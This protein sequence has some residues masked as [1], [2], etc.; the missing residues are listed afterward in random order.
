MPPAPAADR[1]NQPSEHRP[2][3]RPPAPEPV[4]PLRALLRSISSSKRDLLSLLP[5]EAYRVRI[6]PLGSS[7]RGI[8]LINEPAVIH[9]IMVAESGEFPKNDLFVGALAPLVGNGVFISHGQDWTRQRR[10]IEPGF[11]H[12]HLQRAYPAMLGAV[13]ACLGRLE[14]FVPRGD[15][16]S[17]NAAMTHVTADVMCRTIFSE[18]LNGGAAER[19]FAAFGRFQDS[20]A[21]VDVL[22]LLL[23]R[24][25]ARVAQPKAAVKAGSDI[26]HLIAQM[27]EARRASGQNKGHDIASDLMAARDSETDTPFTTEEL[28][29]QIGVFFLAGHETTASTLTWALYLL[30]QNRMAFDDLRQEIDALDGSGLPAFEQIR[31]LRYTRALIKETLRLYPPGPF[32]PRVATRDVDIEGFGLKRGGM[33]MISP[34]LMH[35]HTDFWP[36]PDQFDPS[37]FSPEREKQIPRGAYIPFGLG[38]RVCVGAAFATIEASLI[39]AAIVQRYDIAV[40]APQTVKPV[41]KLT[42]QSERDIQVR[43]TPRR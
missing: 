32:L 28:V 40:R 26:R 24:P 2:S 18:P 20:V 17:L 33:A 1:S 30:S 41:A 21:N 6:A 31:D 8:L 12:I 39:L 35:R 42:I 23:G 25:F 9:R 19:V 16:F 15:C 38:P 3:Y 37:R 14:S 36:S 29:D 34:W 4:S 10:M 7:R 27:I 13:E 22:R 11:S 43:F 5:D